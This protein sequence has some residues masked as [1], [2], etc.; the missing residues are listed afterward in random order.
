MKKIFL[1][2]L[3]LIYACNKNEDPTNPSQTLAEV[4]DNAVRFSPGDSRQDLIGKGV[5]GVTINNTSFYIGY[6]QVSSANKNPLL[7]R[8]DGDSKV[9]ARTDYET[10]GDDGTG[11][12]LIWDGGNQLYAVFSATGSQGS[13]DGDFRRFAQNGWINSYGAG[14][15]AKISIIARIDPDN[16]D[17]ITAS[18]IKAVKSDGKANS[19]VVKDLTLKQ[20]AILIEARSW[21]SPLNTDRSPMNCDGSS[22]FSYYLELSLDLSQAVMAQANGCN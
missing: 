11:Y 21:Y 7:I 16:G 1:I 19:L 5:P 6:Q 14:G 9:Y 17:I 13:S 4:A 15:G 22:P 20:Q 8:F 3:V 12:G 18:Y 10:S 2:L